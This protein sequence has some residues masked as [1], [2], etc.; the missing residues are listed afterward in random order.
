VTT[1]RDGGAAANATLVVRSKPTGFQAI[2]GIGGRGRIFAVDPVGTNH[3]EN[4]VLKRIGTRN[5]NGESLR[6]SV[7]VCTHNPQPRY[8][9]RTL[10]SL[11]CQ[12]LASDQW[13]L[14]LIDNASAQP[15]APLWD[16]SWHPHGRHIREERIGKTAA[17]LRGIAETSTPLL[18]IV[19]DDNVLAADYL[20]R[21]WAI[22]QAHPN[23]GVLGA[24]RLEPEFEI[25]APAELHSRLNLLALRTTPVP[26]W[27]NNP[28]DH[29]CLPFG[30]GMVV[31]RYI[32]ARYCEFV[33]KLHIGD[34][35]G[36]RGDQLFRGDDDL[37]SW[38][39]AASGLG[40]GI[41]PQLQVTH[42]I[43]AGRL[44]HSY[45]LRLIRDHAYSNCILH[46]L[47]AGTTLAPFDPIRI[48]HLA[49]H[50][51][52]NGIFSARCQWA[53]SVGESK[54]ARFVSANGLRAIGVWEVPNSRAAG[55][56]TADL[57][58][59]APA[60]PRP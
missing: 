8:L 47:V 5:G 45:F 35:L 30:A 38:A 3:M 24:G 20:E 40:F 36:P 55:N 13:E 25:P 19:D 50:A 58:T 6:L 60:A 11:R 28:N 41:F 31:T 33:E 44:T 27:S 12:T 49:L 22:H 4:A 26:Q 15:L 29:T 17:M 42:L 23:L 51:L 57:A 52:R 43:S 37:F 2:A 14:I 32:A 10:D 39:S 9:R 56:S 21:A 7:M 59:S 18:V 34:I 46:Y 1:R 54:A 48:V 16:L 53:T